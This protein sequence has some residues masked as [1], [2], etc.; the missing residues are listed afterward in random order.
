MAKYVVFTKSN[1]RI[2]INPPTEVLGKINPV[3][4]IL[5]DPDTSAVARMPLH[6]WKADTKNNKVIKMSKLEE[7][8]RTEYIAQHGVNNNIFL[9]N[10]PALNKAMAAW[11]LFRLHK[12]GYAISGV[13]LVEAGKYIFEH[14]LK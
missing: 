7:M 2:L 5:E 13:A 4:I 3:Y 8:L 10:T 12:V 14:F 9:E 6:Y 1:A 11:N